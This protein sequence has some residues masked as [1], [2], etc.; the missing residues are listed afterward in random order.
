MVASPG[1]EH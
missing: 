1:L